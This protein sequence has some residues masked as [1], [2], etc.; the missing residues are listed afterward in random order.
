MMRESDMREKEICEYIR[1]GCDAGGIGTVRGNLW[2]GI[3]NEDE[4]KSW[5]ITAL[6]GTRAGAWACTAARIVAA[7]IIGADDPTDDFDD[8]LKMWV[9]EEEFK[10]GK[11][12]ESINETHIN[13]K[14]LPGVFLGENVVA[15]PS[16]EV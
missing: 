14:Y 13:E 3:E 11:L 2:K 16:L 9:Y 8:T 6:C 12:T 15:C 1:T 5:V 10:G 7:N 4:E